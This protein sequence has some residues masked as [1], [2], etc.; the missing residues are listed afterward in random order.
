MTSLQ[1]GTYVTLETAREKSPYG[2]FLT[3]GEQEVLL[4]YSEITEELQVGDRIEVFLFHD[5]EDRL[6]ATMKKPLIQYGETSALEVKDINQRLGLFLEI[7]LGRQML[8]PIRELPE[9][10]ALWPVIGSKVFVTMSRDKQGRMLGR[11]AGEETLTRLC[12]HAPQS[13]KNQWHEATV[14]KSLKMGSFVVID[15]GLLGFGAIGFIHDSER[16]SPLRLGDRVNVR[17]V[18]VREDGR[19]NCSLRAPKEKSMDVDSDTLLT[20]LKE[21]PNG[22]MPYSDETPA[23]LITNKFGMSKSAF[24]RAIGKLMKDGLVYQEGS[25]TYLKDKQDVKEE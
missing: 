25:W 24:K 11:A 1:A 20:F 17:I 7:G 10:K 5:T 3:N 19:A 4:H 16:I 12:F 8:L 18:H 14:Y 23:D 21:R 9:D 2:F 15:G 22:A 13:W 6:A